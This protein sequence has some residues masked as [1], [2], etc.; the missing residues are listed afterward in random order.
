MIQTFENAGIPCALGDDV[1]GLAPVVDGDAVGDE[2]ESDSI[3]GAG[4]GVREIRGPSVRDVVRTMTAMTMATMATLATAATTAVPSRV[5]RRVSRGGPSC[6]P[7]SAS[8][9]PRTASRRRRG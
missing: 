7:V 5:P 4:E 1:V 3:E 9:R 8:C 6:R 2:G